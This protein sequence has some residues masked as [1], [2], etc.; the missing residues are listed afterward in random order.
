M[1]LRL[2]QNPAQPIQ[3]EVGAARFLVREDVDVKARGRHRR[4][5]IL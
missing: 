1:G 2:R 5:M 3:L 4:A